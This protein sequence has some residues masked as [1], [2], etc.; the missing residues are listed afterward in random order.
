MRPP[1]MHFKAVRG[2]KHFITFYA[3]VSISARISH[4]QMLMLMELVIVA[5]SV[6]AARSVVIKAVMVI[7]TVVIVVVVM[8]MMRMVVMVIV[9]VAAI[10]VKWGSTHTSVDA[11]LTSARY[12]YS[13]VVHV[14]SG[15][16][17]SVDEEV[18]SHPKQIFI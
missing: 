10:V 15:A 8:V 3:R 14:C 11:I 18:L 1:R 9:S 17:T 6:A 5:I 12:H 13:T 16:N 2:R 4:K 7:V